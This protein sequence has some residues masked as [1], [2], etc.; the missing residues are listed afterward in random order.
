MKK[1]SILANGLLG[2]LL[3]LALGACVVLALHDAKGPRRG[4]LFIPPRP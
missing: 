4:T 3:A 2:L 1:S